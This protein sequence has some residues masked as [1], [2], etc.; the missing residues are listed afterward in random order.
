[1]RLARR[2]SL[3]VAACSGL[4]FA[5]RGAGTLNTQHAPLRGA[6]TKKLTIDHWIAEKSKK[7]KKGAYV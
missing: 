2:L 6:R 5:V 7:A 1:M 3:V 4:I